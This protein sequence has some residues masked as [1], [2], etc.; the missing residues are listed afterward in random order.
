M[1][2]E[3]RRGNLFITALASRP[4]LIRMKMDKNVRERERERE[5]RAKSTDESCISRES[6]NSPSDD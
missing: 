2:Y 3:H 5:V 1:R 6:R 4:G